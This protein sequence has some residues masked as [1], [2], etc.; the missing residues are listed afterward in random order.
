MKMS[1]YWTT[2]ASLVGMLA[3]CQT[4]LQLV[5]PPELRL[6]FLHFLTRLRHVFSSHIYFDI[7]EIDGVNTNELY[8]AVQLYLSSS[9][10][11]NS[12]VSSSNNNTRLSLTRVPN[13]SSVTFGLSNND[14]ITDVFNGVTV[15]WE[16]VVVQRQ[17]QSF[18]WRPMPE[19]KRGFTLQINKRDKA[20]VLD[21]Y[22]DYIVGKSEEIRRRNEERLLYTNSRGVSLDARSHPWDSVRFKHPSTFDTLAMEPEKKKRIMEDLREFANGQGFY[23][24][25]GRAWKRGYLL[26]GP[27]G[28][29]KSSLIAA[30]ANYLG[31]D[32]YDLELTEVQNNSELRKL[33][34]KTSSK[35]IIVI[36]DI[37][38]SISLTKRGKNKKKNGS[39]EY[40]PGL[41]NGSGLEEPGS[42]VTLS[43][44][45]NFTDG[46][47]SCCG[48]EKIFVFTTNHI[49]KLDSALL[50][51]GRM[52]MHVH[53]GFCKFPALKILLKNYLRLEE[54]DMDGVVLK[55]MEE[56]VEE[57][58]ITPAD[59]SEVLIRNRSDAEKAVRELV[60]V[61]KERVVKRRKS[62]RL[63]KKKEEGEEGEEEAEEEQ[64]K[65]ALDSP[66]RNR[67]VFGFQ[68]EED[69]EEDDKEK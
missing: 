13:S 58:E 51:S 2:M 12:A 16:H 24:K 40:D 41:T 65:R 34:M 45:L 21:S 1:D 50:R 9:V 37:D 31:Y 11:V 62:V 57:A 20:L 43:G 38:C 6:A 61:L 39:Y 15:L 44:L 63:K 30:M 47:W 33:L 3:F 18:S 23:Q 64:E 55:E 67:E 68:D 56:C 25:T 19:E 35:S 48:S 10:T 49:E 32:I 42:S 17:V 36:E 66:N 46:L 14:R 5:F 53:M 52:D 27:P 29:G 69:E 60:S 28:T 8:N 54:E 26:Y 59:V 7:T 22:L 4:I